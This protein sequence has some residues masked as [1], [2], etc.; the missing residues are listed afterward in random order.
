[1]PL[2]LFNI[3]LIVLYF[4]IVFLIG[5]W[6]KRRETTEEYLIAGR[7][8]GSWQTAA[9]IMAVV[10]GM[11]LVG[12][13]ALAY[14]MG[15]GAIWFWVGFSLG[16]ICLGLA[17][18]KIKTIADEHNFLTI[19]DYL[20]TKF[21]YKTGILGAV[22]F[23]IAFFA[24][25]IGQ[26]I[27]GGSLFSPLL[28]ISY[29]VAVLIMGVGTLAYLLLG[30]FKAVI[31]TDFIQFLIMF[32]VFI[33]ILFTINI[34]EFAP[35]QVNLIN[36]GGFS[37]VAFIVL[38]IFAT[39][40]GA[41]IWQR[42]FSAKD[43][44]TVRKGSYISAILFIIFGIA[45]TIIGIAAKNSF[46]DIDSSQALY[47]G[48]LQLVPASFVG[49]ATI[50]ILAA[51]MSTIDTELFY[52][53]SSI[54]KD[55]FYRRNKVMEDKLAGIIKVSLIGVAIV[56]MIIAIFVSEILLILFG[57]ISLILCVS[58]AIV[59]SLFWK[60]KNKAAFL[61]MIGGL[62]ALIALIV[63]GTFSPDNVAIVFPAAVVFLIIGQVSF[64]KQIKS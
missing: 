42:I 58:P 12:Q 22:I 45:L 49:I 24:L 13:A 2:S 21:D 25:L 41:D 48:L 17:A 32:F 55:F 63:T 1:M 61:S 56:S 34:G 10:G 5:F 64:K 11:I 35:E 23:F 46:P 54:A 51:L 16:L 14:D 62:L 3:N 19:S 60:I 44:K 40:A 9:S 52:L 18:K 29:P 27:A 47:Y 15:F 7:K 59:A 50:A 57:I 36:I 33:F 53:S 37:I 4:L 31:K 6:V 26:F 43:V 30:G 8:V 38:G 39:F 28:G 20:F